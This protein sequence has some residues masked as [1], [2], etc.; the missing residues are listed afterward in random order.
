MKIHGKK[1]Y[2]T[3]TIADKNNSMYQNDSKYGE[4]E[5]A[6]VAF[7]M[8]KQGELTDTYDMYTHDTL[9]YATSYKTRFKYLIFFDIML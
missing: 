2:G 1:N 7:P 6:P 4:D 5:E 8:Q 9:Y 3:A